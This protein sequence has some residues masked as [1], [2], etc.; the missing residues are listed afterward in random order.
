MLIGLLEGHTR[1]ARSLLMFIFVAMWFAHVLQWSSVLGSSAWVMLVLLSGLPWMFLAIPDWTGSNTFNC[2]VLVVSV[3]VIEIVRINF[4]FGGFPWSLISYS[5]VAGP[6]E[7]VVRIGGDGLVA[8]A[9]VLV[10]FCL[11]RIVRERKIQWALPIAVLVGTHLMVSS[12]NVPNTSVR[13]AVIQ[14]S[15][16]DSGYHH[17]KQ[18]AEVFANHIQVTRTLAS[19]LKKAR[20]K[21]L[22]AVWP[23]NAA[24]QDPLNNAYERVSIQS[25]VNTLGSPVLV[26]ATTYLGDGI[27]SFNQAILWRPGSGPSTIYSKQRLVPFGEYMPNVG[28]LVNLVDRIGL[29]VNHYVSGDSP[30]LFTNA[31]TTWG[32]VMCFEVSYDRYFPPLVNNGASFITVQSNDATYALTSESAQQFAITRLRAY[33][34]QRD[35]AIASTTGISGFIRSNGEV[36]LRTPEMNSVYAVNDVSLHHEISFTDRHPGWFDRA[37]LAASLVVFISFYRRRREFGVHKGIS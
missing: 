13:V 4:P 37:V 12:S 7:W 35:I 22:I 34:H 26:G 16:P 1:R 10:A 29:S 2:A 14:G 25:V 30:G 24:N 17:N 31:G 15:V 18:A 11:V 19:D 33:E 36:A 27:H 8:F 28:P 3:S 23:E 5:Q 21:V 6:L 32:S 9:V 20:A